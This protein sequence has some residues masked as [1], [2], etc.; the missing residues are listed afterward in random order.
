MT[1]TTIMTMTL[2]VALAGCSRERTDD[3]S[4][5]THTTSGTQTTPPQTD[6]PRQP[7][8]T[9][10]NERDKSGATMTPL[11]Q[12]NDPADLELTQAIRKSVVSDDSL[13]MTAKNVKI[14]TSGG[15][16]VLRGPVMSPREREIVA[17]KAQ[18]FAGAGRVDNQ[19]EYKE[20]TR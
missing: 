7:D 10:L 1:R 2:L 19:L 12:S 13:S 16:V 9:A 8:N 17:A 20:P 11:D 6:L 18:Q 4:S 15:R 14:I 3:A 5:Q